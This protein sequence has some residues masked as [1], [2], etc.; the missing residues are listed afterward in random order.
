MG[1]ANVATA[2]AFAIDLADFFGQLEK[3]A[4]KQVIT[5]YEKATKAD[6]NRSPGADI[7]DGIELDF[8]AVIDISARHI[9]KA[10]YTGTE[11]A[12][13]EIAAAGFDFT[14]DE[15]R[16]AEGVGNY[17]AAE[18]VKGID[19]P[20]RQWLAGDIDLAMQEG[21]STGRLAT[22]L[23]ENYAFSDARAETIARTEVAKADVQ[24]RVESY[25]QSGLAK[26]KRWLVAEEPCDICV[27]NEDDDIIDFEDNFSSG[28]DFP[29]AHPNCECDF[30]TIFE[31]PNEETDDEGD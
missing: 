7:A 10:A 11:T 14:V 13:N 9:K 2:K 28:D 19:D 4:I 16:I 17:N 6:D 23:E 3:K 8:T 26:S 30:E 25:R 15:E 24:A 20:T 5:A 31:N 18:I 27:D 12:Q 21:W 29:P 22:T 1:V